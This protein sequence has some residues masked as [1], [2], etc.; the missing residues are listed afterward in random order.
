[1]NDIETFLSHYSVEMHALVLQARAVIL[2][3]MPG[4]L[5]QADPSANLIGYGM[6]RTYKGLV[7]GIII[8]KTYINLMFAQGAS[9]PD[10]DGLLRGTG[11]RARHIRIERAEDLSAPG[12]RAL[13]ITAINAVIPHS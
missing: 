4:A 2:S 8:Y 6:D 10:P 1:M 13:L 11:K 5:E 3:V 9:L 12:V 7:C